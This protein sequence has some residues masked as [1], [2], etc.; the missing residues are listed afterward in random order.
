MLVLSDQEAR[1]LL[2]AFEAA[3]KLLRARLGTS[4]QSFASNST[5]DWLTPDQAAHRASVTSATMRRWIGAHGLG[6]RV[7]GRLFV[8]A[9]R[10]RRFLAGG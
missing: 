1:Q 5:D 2:D 4:D 6:K 7:G 3:T 10:L 9:R 8:S